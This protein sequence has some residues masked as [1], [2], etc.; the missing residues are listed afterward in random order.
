MERLPEDLQKAAPEE[1]AREPRRREDLGDY[2]F[3]R[4]AQKKE[5]KKGKKGEEWEPY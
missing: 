1:R 2:I 4:E 5:K 3:E